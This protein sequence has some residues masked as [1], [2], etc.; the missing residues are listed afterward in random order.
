MDRDYL[1][2]IRDS[3]EGTFVDDPQHIDLKALAFNERVL[4]HSS[5]PNVP[6][7][8]RLRFLCIGSANID[9][10]FECRMLP[11]LL[12][13]S[14]RRQLG[15]FSP[16]TYTEVSQY[17]QRLARTAHLAYT[18]EIYPAM[19]NAGIRITTHRQRSSAQRSW[20][21]GYFHREVRPLLAPIVVD[22][23]EPF[24]I[25]PTKATAFLIRLRKPSGD[26]FM[27]IVRVPSSTPYLV[28]LPTTLSGGVICCASMS[29]IVRANLEHLFPGLQVMQFT[30]FRVTR[31]G[32]VSLPLE[33]QSKR[34]HTPTAAYTGRIV[35]LEV[36]ASCP[37]SLW[38][39]LL[40]EFHLPVAAL[41]RQSGP[42][43]LARLQQVL[44]IA[45]DAGSLKY[46]AYSPRPHGHTSPIFKRLLEG[47]ILIH[48]PFEGYDQARR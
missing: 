26:T 6:L 48:H 12:A 1:G 17:A 39:H 27:A 31:A 16:Q 42:L 41:F 24:P 20:L 29:S 35:R 10:F 3:T 21:T 2:G 22:G 15:R 38:Q 46:P 37:D 18:S 19:L 40:E 11:H 5:R 9:E 32:R 14:Q 44:E 7:L 28:R 33:A 34:S 4:A 30:R 23:I 43:A 8:E 25:P 36:S 47:D 13:S 45:G